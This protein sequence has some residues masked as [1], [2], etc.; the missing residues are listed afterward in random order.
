MSSLVLPRTW[1]SEC[2][3]TVRLAIP[4]IVGQLSQ[5]LMGLTDTLMIGWVGVS[6][7]AASAFA[8]NLLYLPLMFGIGMS[9]AVSVRVSQARGRQDPDGA[10]EALR[11]GFHI[12]MVLGVI[13]VVGA[14]GLLPLLDLFRQD[15]AVIEHVPVYFVLVAVSMI[16]A[17]GAMAVKNHADGMNRPWPVFWITFGG[18][19]LNVVLNWLFIFGRAGCPALGLEGAGLAT[20]LAR[21]VT[22]WA[23]LAWCRQDAGLRAWIPRHWFRRPDR[24]AIRDLLKIGFPTSMQLLAE[25]SAF[26]MATLI[27][28]GMGAESLAAHQ[29]AISCAATVFM[30]PLGISM[31]LTVRVGEAWGARQLAR[32]RPII[33]SGW[34]LATAFTL[35]SATSFVLFNEAIAGLFLSEGQGANVAAALLL[36]AAAFQFCDALQIVAVGGLRG[37]NDVK[38]PAWIAFGAYW[39]VSLP[40]GCWFAFRL[41]LGVSGMWWGITVGLTLTAIAF[42][43]RLLRRTRQGW[44]QVPKVFEGQSR[45]PTGA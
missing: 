12:T 28:G 1:W 42:G 13:T 19:M 38:V 36:V 25:V 2:R 6:E 9:A 37:M 5:M 29:V 24:T 39:V 32:L 23:M 3:T 17:M 16:P 11:H 34:A 4:L 40:L 10:G 44:D 26:V 43:G 7:L 20:L 41:D 45:V 27:I 33:L 8:N 22:L 31:A 21:L 18:V 30:V 35:L 15:P 14:L